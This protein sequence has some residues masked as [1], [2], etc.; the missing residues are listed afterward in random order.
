VLVTGTAIPT[1]STQADR[2]RGWIAFELLVGEVL[3]TTY[4]AEK[5][6]PIST[7]WN[8]YELR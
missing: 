3:A 4:D 2:G 6:R 1:E 5:Q 7:R 8:A